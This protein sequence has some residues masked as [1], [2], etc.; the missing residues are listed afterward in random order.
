MKIFMKLTLGHVAIA[1]V[2]IVNSFLSLRFMSY[3]EEVISNLVDKAIPAVVSLREAEFASMKMLLAVHTSIVTDNEN[4]KIIAKKEIEFS[5]NL[6]R[7]AME[8]YEK[9]ITNHFPQHAKHLKK[10][11]FNGQL[12][13][14][15][16]QKIMDLQE[17]GHNLEEILEY[18]KVFLIQEN[19][20]FNAIESSL[21]SQRVEWERMKH[22]VKNTRSRALF[23]VIAMCV[24]TIFITLFISFRSSQLMVRP[25]V[26]IKD[27]AIEVGKGNF[28]VQISH[29]SSKDEIS[30]LAKTFSSIVQDLRNRKYLNKIIESMSDTLVVVDIEGNIT[31]VNKSLLDLL[32]YEKDELIGQPYAKIIDNDEMFR[33]STITKKKM[34]GNN[35]RCE[36][37]KQDGCKISMALSG[38]LLID[39]S[40]KVLGMLFIAQDMT[41]RYEVQFELEEQKK[42][43]HV[44]LSSIADAI[45]TTDVSGKI[46]F[47]NYV[48]ENLT[49]WNFLDGK[50]KSIEKVFRTESSQTMTEPMQRSL[51][52]KIRLAAGTDTRL[53]SKDGR[54]YC[55]ECNMTPLKT[56]DNKTLGVVLV[57]RDVTMQRKMEVELLSTKQ[58]AEFA[59]R[60][61]SKFLATMSHEIRTPINGVIGMS[62]LLIHTELSGKQKKYLDVIYTSSKHLLGIVNDILDFSK[63]ESGK[64]ELEQQPF[65]LHKLINELITLFGQRA[66]QKGI[67]ITTQIDEEVPSVVTSDVVRVRQI[68]TNLINNAI[69]F[70]EEGQITIS[71]EK[72]SQKDEVIR[73]RFMVKDTGIG[74]AKEKVSSIFKAFSQED[75]S[76]ARKYGGSGLGLAIC[77]RLVKLLDGKIW[78]ESMEQIGSQFFFT[79]PVIAARKRP[80]KSTKTLNKVERRS[81][82]KILVAD[83]SEVNREVAIDTLDHLGY[84]AKV[85]NDGQQVLDALEKNTYDIILM[86]VH[87]PKLNGLET[88]KA[89]V[90]KY[91]EN[92]PLLI[93]LT[94]DVTT[95]SRKECLNS[96]MSD[97]LAKPFSLNSMNEILKKWK[98]ALRLNKSE[99]LESLED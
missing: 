98:K 62:E 95:E 8:D 33:T 86:D 18:E 14:D 22:L 7:M 74:I 97:F 49:G 87:M 55:V 93:A 63:I 79:L 46:T 91:G 34:I 75:T 21:I 92:R 29:R 66:Q 12:F 43:L 56:E 99:N 27:A 32:E 96:G 31:M 76:I 19:E 90:Q 2:V 38:S 68:L 69:K 47:M 26:E 77:S 3:S 1:L 37:L 67:K 11:K 57:F 70:T 23:F 58:K 5:K 80:L 42:F 88:A 44:T 4:K 28:D 65:D 24:F 89:I 54:K 39:S 15:T 16:C 36:Y 45:I 85:V 59:A 13:I 25:I 72:I 6:C 78:V 17:K 73:L 94:A 50:G 82:L 52:K 41:E 53:I 81:S 30:V 71:I 20:F 9:F 64:L 84:N 61:K 60:A 40:D 10:I 35:I 51:T 83:D 48:A